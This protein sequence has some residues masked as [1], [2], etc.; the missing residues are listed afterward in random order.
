MLAGMTDAIQYHAERG[1]QTIFTFYYSGHARAEGLDFGAESI[2]L[3]RLRDRLDALPT[4]VTLVVLDACRSGA[5]S[6]AKGITPVADFSINAVR[7]LDARGMAVLTSSSANELSQESESIGG[8][9]FTH[10]LLVGLRGAAERNGDGR[11]SL[12][13]AYDYAY[14]QTLLSTART[15]LGKQH[16][17]FETRMVGHGDL[18]LTTPDAGQA[19]L[20]LS[21]G[22]VGDVVV[23][24]R[25]QRPTVVAE[26]HKVAGHEARIAVPP[27]GYR[28]LIRQKDR[29]GECELTVAPGAVTVLDGT[30]CDYGP[31]VAQA[32]PKG[33]AARAGYEPA[34]VGWTLELGIGGQQRTQSPYLDRLAGFGYEEQLDF[35]EVEGSLRLGKRITPHLTVLLGWRSLD[36]ST[37]RLDDGDLVQ[38]HDYSGQA[39]EGLLRAHAVGLDGLVGAYAQLGLGTARVEDTLSGAPDQVHWGPMLSLGAGGQLFA[40]SLVGVYLEGTYTV[41]PALENRLGDTHDLGGF[42]AMFGLRVTP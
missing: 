27:G 37:W 21:A 31:L 41:A 32:A 34:T 24:T 42:G 20:T 15:A 12:K 22:L 17:R 14:N 26:L 10:H 7:Q 39:F 38:D 36:A 18:P 28:A 2:D 3:K 6:R 4:A 40:R 23:A 5:F 29:M 1:E 30:D 35:L 13:E 25:A 19:H 33:I 11:V 8:S 9:Y 16:V